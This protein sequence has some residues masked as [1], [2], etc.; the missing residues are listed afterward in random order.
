MA[1]FD[2]NGPINASSGRGRELTVFTTTRG[3]YE[4]GSSLRKWSRCARPSCATMSLRHAASDKLGSQPTTRCNM[5]L[6]WASAP[7]AVYGAAGRQA[8]QPGDAGDSRRRIVGTL[9]VIPGLPQD[10]VD[11][12]IMKSASSPS[13]LGGPGFLEEDVRHNGDRCCKPA[14]PD[15]YGRQAV[16]HAGRTARGETIRHIVSG[17]GGSWVRHQFTPSR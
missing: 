5:K 17:C 13:F 14:W 7:F 10:A 12:A 6:S 11:C 2:D 4:I 3:V 1:L 15:C 8:G 16:A 9:R